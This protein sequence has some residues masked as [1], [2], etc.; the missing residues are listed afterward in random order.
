MGVVRIRR[1][2]RTSERDAGGPGPHAAPR[3]DLMDREETAHSLSRHVCTW[4][5]G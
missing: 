4:E 5:K 2:G 1:G 3:C